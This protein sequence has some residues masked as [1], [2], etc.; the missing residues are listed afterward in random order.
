MWPRD[1]REDGNE[2][3]KRREDGD[4]DRNQLFS[5]LP[6]WASTAAAS[7]QIRE[8]QRV[9]EITWRQPQARPAFS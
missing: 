9:G 4:E 8:P 7:Y 5:E 1:P 6:L 2:N 3:E